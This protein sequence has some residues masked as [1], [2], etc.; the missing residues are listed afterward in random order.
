MKKLI[1]PSI[2][3]TDFTRLG[4]EINSIKKAGADWIHVDV[5]DG[6]FVPNI[7]IGLPVVASLTAIDPP[8]M[9]IH[10]MIENPDYFPELFIKAGSPF[11]KV[12][13][14]QIETCKLLHSTI[15]TIKSHGVMA[16]RL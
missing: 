9:D 16:G 14:I 13:T 1:L 6:H 8:S 2:L 5:M 11:V 3:Y 12:L 10:L 15:S 4:D 7:S